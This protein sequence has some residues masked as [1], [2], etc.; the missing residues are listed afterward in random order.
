MKY[1]NAIRYGL[2]TISL[3]AVVISFPLSVLTAFTGTSPCKN[4]SYYL[5]ATFVVCNLSQER[6]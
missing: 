2:E 3:G 4:Y 5:P 6:K 1:I